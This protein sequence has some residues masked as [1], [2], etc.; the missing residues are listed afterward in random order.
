MTLETDGS[1]DLARETLGVSH[2]FDR[3]GEIIPRGTVLFYEGDP[4]QEMYIVLSGKV[5]ISK[6]VRHV[7]KT[8]VVLGKGE[9]FGE[10]AILNSR[11]RSATATVIED[12]KILI[13]DRETFESMIR[14]NGEI[15][16]RVIKKLAARLQEA[17]NQIENL[18]LKDNVSRLVN[19]LRRLARERG[20]PASGEFVMDYPREDLATGAGISERQLD[21]VL[22]K[23]SAANMVR[24]VEGRISILRMEALEKF[25]R[26]LEMKDQFGGLT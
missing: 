17:N 22:K 18:L 13:I 24:V 11:P 19:L 12:C 26:F 1:L 21:E 5:R 4:G 3:Y 20:A 16:V 9:F 6:R 7:E 2:L 25:A 15:A 23:L 10:M 14:S 8:L